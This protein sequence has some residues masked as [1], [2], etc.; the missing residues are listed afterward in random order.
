MDCVRTWKLFPCFRSQ[1]GESGFGKG[2]L[3]LP[4]LE[5]L[6]PLLEDARAGLI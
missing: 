1:G 4:L 5:D 6:L 3:D 2:L